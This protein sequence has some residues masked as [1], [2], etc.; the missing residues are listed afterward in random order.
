MQCSYIIFVFN[1]VHRYREL[2]LYLTLG[3][4]GSKKQRLAW[5]SDGIPKTRVTLAYTINP[6]GPS[7][8]FSS[9]LS[10]YSV[11]PRL[12]LQNAVCRNGSVQAVISLQCDIPISS[13]ERESQNQQAL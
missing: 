9:S 4:Q 12:Y 10:H 3:N 7:I 2:W 8:V 1:I 5:G 13:G 6:F 11:S